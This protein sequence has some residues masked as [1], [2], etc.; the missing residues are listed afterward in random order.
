MMKQSQSHNGDL[1]YENTSFKY[2]ENFT[3]KNDNFSDKKNLFHI[4]AQNIVCGYSL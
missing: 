3:T 2:S 4:S 1:L